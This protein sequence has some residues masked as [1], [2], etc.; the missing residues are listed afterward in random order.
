MP[1]AQWHQQVRDPRY[2]RFDP[3]GYT[4]IR[5][6]PMED[7]MVLYRALETVSTD[8]WTPEGATEAQRVLAK[9]AP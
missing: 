5:V 2:P 8:G 9:Y 3:K 1:V 7:F 4:H 6:V